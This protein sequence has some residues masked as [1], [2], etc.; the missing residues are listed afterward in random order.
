M[1]FMIN[2]MLVLQNFHPLVSEEDKNGSDLLKMSD[3]NNISEIV[4]FIDFNNKSSLSFSPADV[5]LIGE[6]IVQGSILFGND[7]IL[8]PNFDSLSPEIKKKLK[9]GIYKIGDSRQVEGDF[10]ATIVDTL[11]NNERVKDITL[12]EVKS[13]SGSL[14]SLRSISVQ[15][16]L[17]QISS[18][19]ENIQTL[20]MFQIER[21]RDNNIIVP[22]LN[23]RDYIL[24]TQNCDDVDSKIDYLREADKH[25]IN[26]FNS[27]Y[28][29]MK[30]SSKYLAIVE[31][32]PY[33]SKLVN[34]YMSYIQYDMAIATKMLGLRQTL[35]FSLGEY[36]T[37]N[38]A[39]QT[40]KNV[41]S[42]LMY[43]PIGRN[44]KSAIE[45]MHDNYPYCKDNMDMWYLLPNKID[46]FLK[47]SVMEEN[48]HT[49]VLSLEEE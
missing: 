3:F 20:S 17:K 10:R 26:G 28:T 30:T 24:K 18:S 40:Y 6:T 4:S 32:I 23:A 46:P 9:E 2:H 5:S 44:N 49:Y 21:D 39:V 45:L 35:L 48:K 42:T 31:R 16:Q 33:T 27:I 11:N 22:F 34:A 13:T 29:D 38:D 19:L 43:Q 7:K 8:I 14:E 12:K 37:A 47:N 36:S 15:L 41:I 1:I 25:M